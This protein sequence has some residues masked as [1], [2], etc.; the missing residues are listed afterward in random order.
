MWKNFSHFF[1]LGLDTFT[2]ETVMQVLRDLAKGGRTVVCTI[3]Q[4]NTFIFDLFD[5][6]S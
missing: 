1:L 6:V 3:H 4:P 2:A 5:Q